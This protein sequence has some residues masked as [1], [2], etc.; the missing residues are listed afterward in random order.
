MFY[1]QLDLTAAERPLHK[2]CRT[3]IAKLTGY[4]SGFC[5]CYN[6]TGVERNRSW[7]RLLFD[8]VLK[9]WLEVGIDLA[10]AHIPCLIVLN[11]LEIDATV[12]V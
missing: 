11:Q 3:L 4:G 2:S 10:N 8:F 12:F 6:V 1:A 5:E 7:G 9:E